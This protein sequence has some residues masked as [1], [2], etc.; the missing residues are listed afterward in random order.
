RSLTGPEAWLGKDMANSPVWI[1]ELSTDALGE[2]D[3]ALQHVRRRG[4]PWQAMTRADFP[5]PRLAAQLQ[6]VADELERGCGMVKLRRIPVDRYDGE[7]L[8]HIYVGI[9]AHVGHVLFQNRRGELMRDIRD[10]GAEVG[11]RYGQVATNQ[12]GVFLS[13][14]AR[15]LSNGALRFHT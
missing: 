5:L 4:V 15:T 12:G 9:A 10:E 7:A 1:R 14:Y 6:G 3:A 8:R 11:R 13:S 2:I